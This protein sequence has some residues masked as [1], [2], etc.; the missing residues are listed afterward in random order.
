MTHTVS[1]NSKD[2]K[3]NHA[4]MWIY[5]VL[6]KHKGYVT[7]W[8]ENKEFVAEYPGIRHTKT[9]EL[10]SPN[11]MKLEITFNLITGDIRCDMNVTREYTPIYTL[12]S[13]SP[14]EYIPGRAVFK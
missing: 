12:G 8:K 13:S 6:L 7:A 14:V 1:T 3:V 4:I 5:T 10:R 11:G 2:G 9:Y